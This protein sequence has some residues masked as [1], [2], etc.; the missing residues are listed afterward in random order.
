MIQSGETFSPSDYKELHSPVP[1]KQ[2]LSDE[3]AIAYLPAQGYVVSSLVKI[4]L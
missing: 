4:A 1:L 3:T 2:H